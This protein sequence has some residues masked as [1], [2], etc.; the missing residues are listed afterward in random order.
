MLW[1]CRP[2][3]RSLITTLIGKV[4]SLMAAID[5]LNAKEAALETVV[6]AVGQAVTANSA[7]LGTIHAELVAALANQGAN[8][9]PAIQAVADKLG[10]QVPLLQQAADALNAAAASNPDPNVAPAQPA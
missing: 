6:A 5:D 8:Q 10:A 2:N 3:L 9:D 4:N 1:F 7:L